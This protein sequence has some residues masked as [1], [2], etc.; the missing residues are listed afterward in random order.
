MRFDPP[1]A[2]DRMKDRIVAKREDRDTESLRRR[3]GI[4][5]RFLEIKMPHPLAKDARGWGIRMSGN[6]T[7][8]FRPRYAASRAGSGTEAKV[9]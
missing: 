7:S 2:A 8:C 5:T 6:T 9:R 1:R 4:M 3:G